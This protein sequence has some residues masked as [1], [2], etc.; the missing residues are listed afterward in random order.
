MHWDRDKELEYGKRALEH[1]HKLQMG[2]KERLALPTIAPST[3][4]WKAWESY[5]LTFLG[6]CPVAMQRIANGKQIV[7]TVPTQWP[8]W[9]DDRYSTVEAA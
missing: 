8:E 6:F 1:V 9:F 2:Q 7:M 3:P 5:F 4:E